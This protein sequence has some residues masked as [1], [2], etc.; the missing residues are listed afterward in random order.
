M[1][2][3]S[4]P[5]RNHGPV[6]KLTWESHRLTVSGLGIAKDRV[7]SMD[8]LAAME[9]RSLPVT[10]VCAGNRR[11]EVNMTKPSEGF[12]WGPAAVST[13]VWTGVPLYALL[14][15]CGINMD[16]AGPDSWV[17][18]DGPD[19]ELPKGVYGTSVTLR[20][21]MD[22]SSDIMVAFKQNHELLKPDHG[23]PVRIIIP[24]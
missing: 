9:L 23:F 15:H 21:A 4:S 2:Y 12:S 13:S 3:L 11:K 22:P 20:K 8:Q 16:E 1:L 14:R 24:G 17:C 10:L 7:F 18:F 6:P 19:G 5:S